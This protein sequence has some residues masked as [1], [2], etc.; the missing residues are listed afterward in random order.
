MEVGRIFGGSWKNIG[1]N[2]EEYWV[3]I[4]RILGESLK[5]NIGQKTLEEYWVEVG[6][7]L[8]KSWKSIGWKLEE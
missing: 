2:F 7:I 3:E 6:R 8:E 4:G 5:N 1:W